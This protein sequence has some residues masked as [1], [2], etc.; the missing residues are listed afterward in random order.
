M[1]WLKVKVLRKAAD[2]IPFSEW[3]IHRGSES[4]LC[5]HDYINTSYTWIR[6]LF[7]LF[8][9]SLKSSPERE[10]VCKGARWMIDLKGLIHKRKCSI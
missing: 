8:F 6:F 4:S 10:I 2:E 9:F 1:F 5:V 7:L 3:R